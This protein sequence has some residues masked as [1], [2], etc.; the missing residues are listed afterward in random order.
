MVIGQEHW[1][2]PHPVFGTP[3]HGSCQCGAPLNARIHQGFWW[4]LWNPRKQYRI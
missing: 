2:R 1:N 3:Y 4:R